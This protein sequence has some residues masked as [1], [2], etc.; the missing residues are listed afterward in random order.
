MNTCAP[1]NPYDK[2]CFTTKS[3]KSIAR[4]LNKKNVRKIKL[5]G[6]KAKLI[7]DISKSLSCKGGLDFCVLKKE[8]ELKDFRDELASTFKPKRPQGEKKYWWLSN[9]DIDKVMRQYM[10][11][12]KNFL[13]FGAVPIDFNE[14]YME[15]A[16]INL[17]SLKKKGKTKLGFVFNL[18]ASDESG[19]H[20]V[21]MFVDLENGTVC[22]FDSAS[23]NT[24]P[25]EVMKLIRKLVKQ[26][27]LMKV[28]LKFVT[29]KNQHQ[30]SYTECGM[31]S[32]WFIISRLKG[33]SCTHL[34]ENNT[35]RDEAMKS[36]RDNY[37]RA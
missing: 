17:K 12:H 36:L 29:N 9:L 24:V 2:T 37:F 25:K 32:L 3:L 4:K 19:S 27:K 14:I 30:T 20:W 22:F 18:D 5:D 8:K 15:I 33:K 7:K 11:K 13:F 21:S 1:N 28:P 6:G 34:F 10:K 16:N 23:P 26:A 35:S 31:F